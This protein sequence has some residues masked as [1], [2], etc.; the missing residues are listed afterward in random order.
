MP[1]FDNGAAFLS[2]TTRDYPL[3]S[4]MGIG[5]L[6]SRVRGKPIV[7]DFDKQLAAVDEVV[8][9][10]LKFNCLPDAIQVQSKEYSEQIVARIQNILNLQARRYPHLFSAM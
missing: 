4:G 6:I 10:S 1:V 9:L 5:R 7:T 3:D 8:G 2:D